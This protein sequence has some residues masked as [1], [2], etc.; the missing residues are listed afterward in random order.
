MKVEDLQKDS[1]IL[2]FHCKHCLRDDNYGVCCLN[3]EC[4]LRTNSWDLDYVRIKEC[5]CFELRDVLKQ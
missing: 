4:S 2:C 3:Q 1:I 5:E